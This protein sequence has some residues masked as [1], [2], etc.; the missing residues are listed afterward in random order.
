MGG[1]GKHQLMSGALAAMTGGSASRRL[2]VGSFGD[3]GILTYGFRGAG[4]AGSITP[5]EFL[6]STISQIG[7][8]VNNK[9]TLAV[10]GSPP[11]SGWSS[12]IIN[13]TVFLRA[14]AAFVSG[15]VWTWSGIVAN[16]IGTTIEAIIPVNIA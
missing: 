4:V 6:G 2:T 11:N 16:P 14:D 10:F 3:S 5:P 13:G 7:W 9:V 1:R 15:S 8:N 12:M